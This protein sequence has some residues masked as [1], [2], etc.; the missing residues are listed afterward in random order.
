LPITASARCDGWSGGSI[1]SG[2]HRAIGPQRRP[3]PPSP[4]HFRALQFAH[5]PL[6]RPH[7]TEIELSLRR[8]DQVPAGLAGASTAITVQQGVQS[9]QVRLTEERA[10]PARP[11][12]HD[13]SE[14]AAEILSFGAKPRYIQQNGPK[15][16]DVVGQAAGKLILGIAKAMRHR[17]GDLPALGVKSTKSNH[18]A[19]GWTICRL[20][21]F[22]SRGSTFR[23]W[24]NP[25]FIPCLFRP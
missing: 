19:C 17:H 18:H 10:F 9:P 1:S 12:E 24:T 8:D 22:R 11:A 5:N 4:H 25:R 13:L 2:F 21:S 14:M 6:V 20:R 23:A 3:S 16:L 15:T 7:D